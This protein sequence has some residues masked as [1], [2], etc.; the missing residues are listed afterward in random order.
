LIA[1]KLDLGA[2][3]SLSRSNSRLRVEAGTGAPL[4]P[5]TKT[6]TDTA[7]VYATYKLRD[8]LSLTGSIWYERYDADD[9]RLDGVLP[10]TVQ[11]LLAF[12]QQA[13]HHD[14]AAL[15]MALRYRF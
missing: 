5:A 10:A 6:A 9:W 1:D 7:K 14:L 11:T 2:D 12:G 3:L 4:F 8:K 13:Q 15:Q